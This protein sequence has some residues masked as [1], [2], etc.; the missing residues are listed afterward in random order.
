MRIYVFLSFVL[1]SS[2]QALPATHAYLSVPDLRE[3]VYSSWS[4]E[5]KH[6]RPIVAQAIAE[7]IAHEGTHQ[8]FYH[9]QKA[10]LRV[11][12]DFIKNLYSF[13]YPDVTIENFYF[14]RAWYDFPETIHAQDFIDAHEHGVPKDWNDNRS[15]LAKRMLSV[16]FSLFGSTKNYG[17]FGEC[18]F[19]Y[20]FKNKSIK[21]P[22]IERLLEEIFDHFGFNKKY[23][24]KLLSL[25]ETITT[26]EGSLFQIFVPTDRVDQIAFAAQR[27]GTP[28]RNDAL[29]SHAFDYTKK[30]YP[31]LTPLLDVYCYD[32]A[33]FGMALDRLQGRL[34][35]S[36]DVLLNPLSGVKIFRYTTVQPDKLEAYSRKL[37]ETTDCIFTSWLRSVVR[38]EN[39]VFAPL[40]Y[41]EI[42]RLEEHYKAL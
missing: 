34:L 37:K 28:Y 35:F 17:N 41:D 32:P 4:S 21:A 1:S 26:E 38:G 14:L 39:A 9:A 12:Q 7:E 40:S 3:L 5:I 6:Y 11:V 29:L 2:L 33:R 18:S 27:L 19:K 22:Q 13:L 25:S 15:S 8:V 23:I 24:A 30:R 31:L 42:K 10:E 20:F 36:Q 16:N